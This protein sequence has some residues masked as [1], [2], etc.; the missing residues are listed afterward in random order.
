MKFIYITHTHTNTK[1][2]REKKRKGNRYGVGT[3]LWSN[4]SAYTGAYIEGGK[5]NGY[6]IYTYVDRSVFKGMFLD[7]RIN[8][9][10]I[11]KYNK[12]GD[13]VQ[14]V[15]DNSGAKIKEY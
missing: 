14:G 15:F 7:D 12:T 10:G 13:I 2:K 6:G 1:R 5:R 4:K 11:M 3:Y 8:G 9:L